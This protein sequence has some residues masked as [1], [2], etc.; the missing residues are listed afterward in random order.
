MWR[1]PRRALLEQWRRVLLLAGLFSL[2]VATS[3]ILQDQPIYLLLL[4]TILMVGFIALTGRRVYVERER[5]FELLRPFLASQRIY[6]ALLAGATAPELHTAEPFRALC[7]DMLDTRVAY[8]VAVGAL[9]PLT[10]N[11][12]V[13]PDDARPLSSLHALIT[14]CDNPEI[15][16]FALESHEYSDAA[17]AVPLWHERRLMGIL[18]LGEKRDGGLYTRE[19]ME[20][21]RS[22]GER[23]LDIRASA[24]I[25]Q[26]LMALQ[27]QRLAETRVVDHRTRRLLHDEILPRLHT[28]M[29]TMSSTNATAEMNEGLQQLADVHREISDLL[30]AMPSSLTEIAHLGLMPALRQTV[31]QEFTGAF[32]TLDWEVSPEAEG[33]AA[34]LTPLVAEVAFYAAR[35]ALRNAARYARG[36]EPTRALHLRIRAEMREDL[37]LII[38][39]DGI[40]ADTVLET[41]HSSGQGLALHGTMMAVIGGE[42][43]MESAPGQFTRIT[44]ILPGEGNRL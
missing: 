13:Y 38:E 8:L 28:A 2:L 34:V 29:L 6:D 23:L 14:R 36:D 7:A 43:S 35:E 31:Q 12:L 33:R 15:V 22:A 21:A 11:P 42:L 26:R 17:W 18:L 37:R 25:A 10:G 19:E 4:A 24:S 40:G 3:L 1:V 20:L 44:L 39:D 9:S 32:D 30:H 27:R 16:C 41:S 5:Y